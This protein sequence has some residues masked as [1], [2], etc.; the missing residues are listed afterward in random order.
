MDD[1][2][3]LCSRVIVIGKGQIL[4][5]GSLDQLRSMVSKE[6]RLIVELENQDFDITEF[7][8]CQLFYIWRS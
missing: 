8:N 5:D 1:I 4:S 6:R 3:A 7:R 2:E